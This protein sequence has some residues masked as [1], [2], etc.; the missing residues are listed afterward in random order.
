LKIINN[1]EKKGK[2]QLFLLPGSVY[3]HRFLL[4]VFFKTESYPII[5]NYFV[6]LSQF[7]KELTQ[8]HNRFHVSFYTSVATKFIDSPCFKLKNVAFTNFAL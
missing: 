8:I 3:F 7:I 2:E 6:K 5:V 4:E 1:L